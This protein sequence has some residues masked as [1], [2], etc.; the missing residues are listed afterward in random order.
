MCQLEVQVAILENGTVLS[1]VRAESLLQQLQANGTLPQNR[2]LPELMLREE[3]SSET[4][5]EWYASEGSTAY[6]VEFC[7]ALCRYYEGL[8]L[9]APKYLLELQL[10]YH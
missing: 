5:H 9:A 8:L 7:N 3:M 6:P 1:I 4:L 2:A 10:F